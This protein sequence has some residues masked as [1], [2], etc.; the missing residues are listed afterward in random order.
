M[1]FIGYIIA[2][3]PLAQ[4]IASPLFGWW[5]NRIR[6]TRVPLIVTMVIFAIASAMYATISLFPSERKYWM[7]VSRLLVGVSSGN[8]VGALRLSW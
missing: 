1:D 6:S 2:A 4:M 5:S 3:N 7:I 8:F